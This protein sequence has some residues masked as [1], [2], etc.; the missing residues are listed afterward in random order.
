MLI[1]RGKFYHYRFW[2]NGKLYK[3]TTKK[4]DKAEATSIEKEIKK[5]IKDEQSGEKIVQSLQQ[6]LAKKKILLD[7]IFSYFSKSPNLPNQKQLGQIKSCLDDFLHYLKDKKI[8]YA[9]QITSEHANDYISHISKNGKY[10]RLITYTRNGKEFSYES[11]IKHL[12]KRTILDYLNNLKNVFNVILKE[13]ATLENPFNEIVIKGLKKD[14]ESRKAFTPEELRLI[15]EKGKDN[16]LYPLFLTG[17]STGLREGDICNLKWQ[18]VLLESGWLR[19]VEISKTKKEVD[20]PILPGLRSYLENLKKTDNLYV[21]PELHKIYENNS[22]R[23]GKNVTQFLERIGIK[24]SV[25]VKRRSRKASVKDIHSLRH[26]F[27]YLAA[28]HNIPLPIVQSI[29]GHMTSEMTKMYM[30]HAGME[31]K[32]KMLSQMPNYLHAEEIKPPLS[33]EEIK[34]QLSKANE[35][36]WKEIINSLLEEL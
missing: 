3:G 9:A 29:L 34:N 30:D 15:G 10:N 31:V 8:Q 12:S 17:I 13:K 22:T 4:T 20:I 33:N 19:N 35:H 21:F 26:T 5:R 24:S 6:K 7:Q 23:I 14:K 1:L 32:Q 36:N 11:K 18:N 25:S 27:A 2:F 16:Y 28:I